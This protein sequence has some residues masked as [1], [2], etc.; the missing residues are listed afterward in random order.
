[1]LIFLCGKLLC[2]ATAAADARL[3]RPDAT[4]AQQKIVKK[5]LAQL[6]NEARTIL[7]EQKISETD[8][9]IAARFDEQLPPELIGSILI[10]RLNS[11]PFI[12]A[13]SRWQLTS[14]QTTLPEL[15]DAQFLLFM[16]EAP[17]MMDNPW[18]NP[19]VVALFEKAEAAGPLSESDATALQRLEMEL[20]EK[21]DVARHLNYPAEQ[22]RAWVSKQIGDAGMRPRL[23]LLGECRAIINAGWPTRSIKTQ[24][25]RNFTDSTVDDTF[26]ERDRHAVALVAEQMI[27]L[28]RKSV[29]EIGVLASGAVD[30]KYSTSQVTSAD[31]E[32]WRNRLFGRDLK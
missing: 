25:T 26:T 28:N 3:P 20:K 2:F 14:Y 13:Y 23:W 8:P 7:K 27:G 5:L 10:H 19:D 22:F 31:A 11:D 6:E 12:D 18:A 4:P 21:E 32:N 9:D 17:A 29:G 16:D 30:V 15:T 24:I 1:M